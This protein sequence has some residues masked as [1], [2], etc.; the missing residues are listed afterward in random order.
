MGET[1]H[2]LKP[3]AASSSVIFDRYKDNG[4]E[5]LSDRSRRRFATPTSFLGDNLEYIVGSDSCATARACGAIIGAVM[6]TQRQAN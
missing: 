5:A 6:A 1:G 4:L 2:A 3:S